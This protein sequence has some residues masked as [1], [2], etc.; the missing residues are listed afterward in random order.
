MGV[1]NTHGPSIQP[2][3]GLHHTIFQLSQ[4]VIE[5]INC[6]V[7]FSYFFL[8]NHTKAEAWVLAISF[9]ET[10]FDP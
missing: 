6:A 2:T 3:G 5:S 10:E 9:Y 1:T 7:A 8:S 4:D